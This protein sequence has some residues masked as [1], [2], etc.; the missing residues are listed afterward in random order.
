MRDVAD[1]IERWI[2]EGKKVA[3]A[4]VIRTWGSAP[5]RVGANMAISEKG[6]IAGSVSG[7]CVEGV[8]AETA[9]GVLKSNISELL[10]FGVA[11]ETA[12]DVGLACGGEID[13]FV[14]PLNSDIFNAVLGAMNRELPLRTGALVMGAKEILGTHILQAE[15]D[16]PFELN[17]GN[18]SLGD[19]LWQLLRK[20]V[21]GG[22]TRVDLLSS[23]EGQVEI[24]VNYIAP[25][26][27][28]V[29]VGGAHAAIVLSKLAKTLDY[30]TV[31]VDPR[32]AFG[33]EARFPEVDE[34]LQMWPDKAFS[35]LTINSST[36]VVTLTHDPKIDD[37]A[38]IASL[39]SPAFY[40]GALGSRKSHA[41][42]LARLNEVGIPEEKL[43]KIR[44]PIGLDI[45]A[46]T[47]EEIALSVMAEIVAAK[48]KQL[49]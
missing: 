9:M 42:R 34:L 28:L 5:R 22:D 1:D 35:K 8:V 32:N 13:V 40:V 18:S 31:I 30:R 14:E 26:P 49:G 4:T 27:T 25:S 11:D 7:G 46:Q 24:F 39:S 44:G 16:K 2:S 38:L 19:A 48:H 20:G 10:H 36:A 45:G 12:W 43:S 21:S 3:L 23:E 29:I 47:P 15:G 33:N 6:E 37:P 17:E 41:K